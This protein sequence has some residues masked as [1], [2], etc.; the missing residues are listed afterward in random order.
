MDITDH[1]GGNF[2]SRHAFG[3]FG[4]GRDLWIGALPDF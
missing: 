4:E 2:L 3:I 1:F